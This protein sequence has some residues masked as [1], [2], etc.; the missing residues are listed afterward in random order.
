MSEPVIQSARAR[1][2]WDSRGRPTVEAEV[3]LE[4]RR[5]GPRRRA[6]RRLARQRARRSTGATAARGSAASTFR[7]R[8]PAFA[9]RSRRRCVGLDPFDQA[10]DR[11]AR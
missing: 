5:A 10:G 9:T 3:A 8:W 7:A 2:I 6:G 1:R 11:R 4:R